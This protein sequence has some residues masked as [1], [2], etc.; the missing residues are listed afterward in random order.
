MNVRNITGDFTVGGAEWSTHISNGSFSL[1]SIPRS[2]GW[3]GGH[4]Q[5]QEGVKIMFNSNTSTS[6]ENRPYNISYLPL[7]SY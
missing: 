4:T 3:F 6:T 7:I 1:S 2:Q 5:Q